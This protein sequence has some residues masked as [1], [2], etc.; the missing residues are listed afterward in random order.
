MSTKSLPSQVTEAKSLLEEAAAQ[1]P[2]DIR[3][4][5]MA[6]LQEAIEFLN[7]LETSFRNERS[8]D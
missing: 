1:A 6:N 3:A 4:K 2:D 5:Q 8:D 7:R